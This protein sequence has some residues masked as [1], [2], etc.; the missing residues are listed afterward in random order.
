[1]T[2]EAA[3]LRSPGA[4]PRRRR[5]RAFGIEIDTS[6]PAPGLPALERAGAA[7]PT[8]LDVVRR[9]ELE[10]EWRRGGGERLLEEHFGGRTPARAI[11]FHPERGYRLYARHFGIAAITP[12]G[13]RV[14]C[15]PPAVSPWRWQRFLVG[16]V[17]PW[18]ALLRGLEIFHASAVRIGDQT[19]GFVGPSG[20]GKTSLALQLMLRGGRFVTDDVLALAPTEGGVLAHPGASICAVREAERATLSRGQQRSLGTLLGCSDKAYIAVEREESPAP[21]SALY[22]LRLGSHLPLIEPIAHLDPRLIL[23]ST[24]VV[25]VQSPARLRNHLEVCGEIARNVPVFHLTV[26]PEQ[27]S[28]ALAAAVLDHLG[29]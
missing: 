7:E 2:S 29:R 18:A 26:D 14:R 3:Q 23:S 21:L 19:V 9:D 1:M 8:L 25:S 20:T 22:F 15:A 11:D 28:A 17:L 12:D 24:F 10:V 6:V 5:T 4:A 27:G 16:R 13:M